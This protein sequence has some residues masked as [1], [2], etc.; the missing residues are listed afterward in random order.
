MKLFNPIKTFWQLRTE[1]QVVFIGVF[2]NRAGA[3]V[4]PFLTLYLTEA[5]GFSIKQAG[6]IVGLFGV[7]ALLMDLILSVLLDKLNLIAVMVFSSLFSALVILLFPA[8][9]SFTLICMAMVLWSM[10]NEA[11]KPAAL[12][13]INQLADPAQKKMT[14]AMHRLAINLGISIG[15][16]IAGIIVIWSYN[17]LFIINGICVLFTSFLLWKKL[18]RKKPIANIVV[19]HL[20]SVPSLSQMSAFR[21]KHLM[22]FLLATIPVYMVF[23]QNQSALSLVM[24]NELK[25]PS[26]YYGLTF[27]LNTLLIVLFEVGINIITAKWREKTN[28][29]IGSILVTLG[30]SAMIYV[31]TVLGVFITVMIWTFG[32]IFLFPAE[33]AYIGNLAP[34]DKQGSYMAVYSAS[35]NIAMILG[36][37]LGMLIMAQHG[38]QALWLTCFVWGI[39]SIIMFGKLRGMK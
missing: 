7:G 29:I 14:F 18:L 38:S 33:M 4:L 23:I 30:F 32:E 37:W 28:L 6:V 22:Y 5:R 25:I 39:I 20:P 16:A 24:V 8:F 2:I 15:P 26:F 17:A 34:A 19:N 36:P 13:L 9:S 10:A 31:Q 12:A 3:M 21:D 11:Y 1:L 35:V 27:T